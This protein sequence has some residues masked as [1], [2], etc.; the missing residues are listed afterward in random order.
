[1]IERRKT[2]PYCPSNSCLVPE[3]KQDMKDTFDSLKSDIKEDFAI[4][5]EDL[6]RNH[7][8]HLNQYTLLLHSI[9]QKADREECKELKKDTKAVRAW[10]WDM[11]KM[12]IVFL[13]GIATFVI[14]K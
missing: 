6:Q 14:T 7:S 9:G 2:P 3:V 1:M 11:L 8:E 13:L 10:V 5:R 12:A 4:F